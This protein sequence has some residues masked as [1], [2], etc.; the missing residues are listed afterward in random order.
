M[1][2]DLY[3]A[4]DAVF[5]PRSV[6][7]VGATDNPRKWGYLILNSIIKA[8]YQGHLYPVNPRR[9]QVAGM[10]A[11]P[12]LSAIQEPLDLAVVA[13][14]NVAVP[15][16]IAEAVDCDVKAAIVIT[17]GFDEAGEHELSQRALSIARRG[18]LRLVG[19]NG[20]GVYSRA[21]NFCAMMVPAPM[22]PGNVAFISQSGGYG[23]QLFLLARQVSL[24][25]HSFVSSGNELDLTC[26]DY[27]EYFGDDPEIA[28]VMMY[29]EG[30]HPDEG[31]RFIEV[32]RRVTQHKPVVVIK[33]GLGEAGARAAA[34][35]TGSLVG[36]DEIYAAA[37]HQAGI[38]RADGPEQ[39]FDYV[40]ALTRLPLPR[41]NRVVILTRSG[42]A[43]VAAA[44][45]CERRGLAL[46]PLSKEAREQIE[47]FVPPF[48]S[49]R[50]PVDV[51]GDF[52]MEWFTTAQSILLDEPQF[53]GMIALNLSDL[54]VEG[55]ADHF[56]VMVETIARGLDKA[57]RTLLEEFRKHGKPIVVETLTPNH[58][59]VRMVDAGGLPIYPTPARAVDA[60]AALWQYKIYR[61]RTYDAADLAQP[62]PLQAETLALIEAAQRDNRPTLTEPEAAQV[63]AAYGIPMAASRL[64]TDV[65]EAVAAAETLGY[66]LAMKIV[67]PDILHKTNVGGVVLNLTDADAVCESFPRLV[68]EVRQRRPEARIEGVLVQRM[69]PPDGREVLIGMKRDEQFGVVVLAGLGGIFTEVV[70]DTA[71]RVAPLTV[72]EALEM[73]RELRAYPVLAGARGQAASD[74]DALAQIIVAVSRLALD[75]PAIAEL[76]LNPV[77]VYPA[78]R[79]ALAVDALVTLRP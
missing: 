66:P 39:F 11:V 77:F 48:A 73:L 56:P 3:S 49:A 64:V 78:G 9:A 12:R 69:A 65:E 4:L 18:R 37:F 1:M 45:A 29:I 25:I 42:G 76:D 79:G 10:P 22:R 19:P 23:V 7:V 52:D 71:L 31:P 74:L 60:M 26:T 53:S 36:H 28:A 6:A 20:M 5:R 2:S 44:D 14:P 47:S 68:E 30:L 17:S 72:D 16:V 38:L 75:C 62:T 32:A 46:P 57:G 8:G 41:D 40:K 51:T 43:G 13:V 34:S 50:N 15:D 24:G 61:Q 63:M 27:L 58:P 59:A 35:H 54:T 21:G 70:G 33:T 55:M 67:S